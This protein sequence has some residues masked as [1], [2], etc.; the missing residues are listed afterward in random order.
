MASQ[1]QSNKPTKAAGR[2]AATK[3]E[4]ADDVRYCEFCGKNLSELFS[5]QILVRRKYCSERCR[6]I[7]TNRLAS[8]RLGI[9]PARRAVSKLSN[10]LYFN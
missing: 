1:E 5:P 7:A 2:N 8:A 9:P 3:K 4:D 6:S 10:P